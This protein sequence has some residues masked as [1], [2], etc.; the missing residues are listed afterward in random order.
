VSGDNLCFH[1]IAITVNPDSN[2]HLAISTSSERSSGI[3][4][5]RN[6]CGE[7]IYFADID[8][9]RT[10]RLIAEREPPR[11]VLQEGELP[12]TTK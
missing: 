3:I 7:L 4:K 9:L 2:L 10:L 5:K 8:G 6:F 1:H 12:I 11:L